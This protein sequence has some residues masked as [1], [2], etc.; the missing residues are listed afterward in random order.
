MK[1][2]KGTVQ[3]DLDVDPDEITGGL[4]ESK[5]EY[6]DMIHVGDTVILVSD[7]N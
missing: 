2:W 4:P 1:Q 7:A 3:E 5:N 6:E